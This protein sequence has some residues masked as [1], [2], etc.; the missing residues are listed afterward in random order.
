NLQTAFPNLRI[1]IIGTR[2]YGGYSPDSVNPEPFA[3]ESGFA[4]KWLIERQIAGDPALNW[5]PRAGSVRVP[6]LMWGPYLWG[7]GALPRLDGITWECGD[8]DP[9]GVH[10]S[11]I[12]AAKVAARIV[13]VLRTDPV[14]STFYWKPTPTAAEPAA[15]LSALTVGAPRPNPFRLDLSV[16]VRLARETAVEAAVY[17]LAG[18]RVRELAAGPLAAGAHDLRWD[19]RDEQ[20]QPVAAGTYM[21]R[22]QTGEDTHTVKTTLLR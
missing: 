12:G 5:D 10:P 1:G 18:R 7:D 8:F 20:G 14:T 3:Y 16:P 17:S 19:G 4:S 9:D 2:I 22:V 21:I 15:D 6:W 11:F 13:R